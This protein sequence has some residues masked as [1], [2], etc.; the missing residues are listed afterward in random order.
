MAREYE[1]RFELNGEIDPQLRRAFDSLERTVNDMGQELEELRNSGNEAFDDL[2]SGAMQFGEVFEKTLQFT[3]AHE[4]ITSVGD[5]FTNMIAEVGSLDDSVRQMGAATG[6]TT[7]E[8]AQFKDIIREIYAGNFGEG[9]DDIADSLVNVRRVTGLTGDAL[10]DATKNALIL[11]DTFGYEVNETVQTVDT[12]MRNMG[13]T[14][15]EAFSLIAQGSQKGLDRS[16]D[17]LDTLNEYSVQFKD[18]GYNAEEM[19][20]VLESG[21]KSGNFNLDKTADLLKEFNLRIQSGDD[22]V[23]QSLELLMAPEGIEDFI[24]ALKKG[25]TQ[26]KEYSE[27]LKH[28]SKDT[29]KE[30][31]K[32]LSGSAKDYS[33]AAQAITGIMGDSGKILSGLSDGS[34]KA[35]DALNEV[36][37]ALGDIDDAQYRNQLSVEL[38]GSQYEDLRGAAVQALQ[39]TNG[40]FDKTLNT[41]QQ[42]EDVK[43]SVT[44]FQGLG[45]MLMNEVIIPIG[46]ELLPILYDMT[47][48]AK[49]NKDLVKALAL[50]VPAG[51]LA[52]NAYNM[53]KSLLGTTGLVSKF[54]GA[55]GLLTNPIGLA[56][57]AV[58][59]LTL[60]VMA[61]KKHQEEARQELI[62]M[63]DALDKA[64]DDYTAV[65]NQTRKTREL[66]TEYDR[67]I[68]K[69]NDSQ[70][71]AEQLTEARR[72]LKNVEQEL[73]DLNPDILRAEDAKSDSFREQLGLADQLNESRSEMAR[74]ELE[75]SVMEGEADLPQL[76]EEY[77]RLNQKLA[78]TN[79][80]Y[81][82]AQAS[83]AQYSDYVNRQNEIVNNQSLSYEEQD[84]KL[85][86]LAQEIQNATGLDYSGNWANLFFD[87]NE[88]KDTINDNY[89][90]WKNTQEEI[91]TTEQSFQSLYDNQKKLI[92]LDLGGTIKDQAAKYK[93]LNDAEKQ[94][95]DE[96]LH[97]IR[98]LNSE[99]DMLPTAKKIDV[100]VV[101]RQVGTLPDFS[102][103]DE[104][105]KQVFLHDPDFR[106][107]AD[108]GII[109]SPELA[110]VGEG[111]DREFIIPDNNSKR[112]HAL[113]AAAGEALGYS[114]GGTFAPVYS[115]VLNFYGPAD[116]AKVQAVVKDS[117]REWEQN[118]AAWQRQQQRRNLA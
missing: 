19:F 83:Y 81:Q 14:A 99:M 56:V 61:Y 91:L 27:L 82:D 41:M 87:F 58:G 110:W 39:E 60:G 69:I 88:L 74:R 30:L 43:Y 59:A 68:N 3:G 108:G 105:K 76:E 28:V 18:A 15:D 85:R 62:N 49:E 72:K 10:E 32:N 117:Q 6:A 9:F 20:S 54:G 66:I 116:E 67:L 96:A 107:Y 37:K 17:F 101:M 98:E 33:T 114:P 48:W 12:M 77:D 35:K 51:L 79:K 100:D 109:D 2:T 97:K 42:I 4:L 112:S 50:S 95:F 89:E 36:I 57:G 52:K 111:G 25:G 13:L 118:M 93:D 29:A 22:N 24:T 84:E 103:L 104:S 86:A 70:T 45:R 31:L 46:D 23:L 53:G 65:D 5:M 75:M 34:V 26:T 73:I 44:D 78:E 40:E 92:E 38:F 1:L 11:R 55:V 8:M 102:K 63:G 80:A 113:Y 106:G 21:L 94:R 115:P 90:S 64:Y 71:P 16:G 47:E 7:E